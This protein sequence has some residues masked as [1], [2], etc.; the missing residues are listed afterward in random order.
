VTPRDPRVGL[1]A[2]CAHARV[3]Q[4][5]KRSASAFYRCARA[6]VDARF[7]RYPPLPVHA[8]SGHEPKPRSDEEQ[9]R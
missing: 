5:A 9:A 2:E 8:C 3:Q 1:C 4:S 6:D 7:L